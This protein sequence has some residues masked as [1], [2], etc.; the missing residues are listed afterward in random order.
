V[1]PSEEA[2]ERF[3]R[4]FPDIGAALAELK[5][6]PFP[7]SVEVVLKPDAPRGTA[8]EI[9]GSAKLWPGVFI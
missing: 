8:I 9:A 3:R 6:A 1:I 4:A 2:L 7:P 5:D